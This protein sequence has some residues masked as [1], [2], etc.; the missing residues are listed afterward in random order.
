MQS[1]TREVEAEDLKF[2]VIIKL[3]EVIEGY[4]KT[5]RLHIEAHT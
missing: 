1:S 4:M 3:F 5:P 2:K